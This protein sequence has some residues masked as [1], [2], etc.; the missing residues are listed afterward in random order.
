MR[1]EFDFGSA[2]KLSLSEILAEVPS[3]R[4]FHAEQLMQEAHL[5]DVNQ[6]NAIM[7]ELIAERVLAPADSFDLIGNPSERKF[8]VNHQALAAYRES[9]VPAPAYE[10]SMNDRLVSQQNLSQPAA[11][12]RDQSAENDT[13]VASQVEDKKLALSYRFTDILADIPTGN[14]FYPDQLFYE[15]E[16]G[17][18]AVSHSVM[19]DMAKQGVLEPV[20]SSDNVKPFAEREFRINHEA[21]HRYIGSRD[22]SSALPSRRAE[23]RNEHQGVGGSGFGAAYHGVDVVPQMPDQRDS[24]SG[25]AAMPMVPIS[26]AARL[27]IPGANGMRPPV[28]D[29]ATA[30]TFHMG[31]GRNQSRTV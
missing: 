4:K 15:A 21:L 10:E 2:I 13:A 16:A 20:K 23:T 17:D 27:P 14:P 6:F 3:V 22:G 19:E 1:D 5:G 29:A 31:R 11:T 26:F 12:S 7:R 18:R 9:L 24:L 8:S 28:H 25:R 30:P